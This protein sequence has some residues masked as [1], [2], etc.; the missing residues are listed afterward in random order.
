MA[1]KI[2]SKKEPEKPKGFLGELDVKIRNNRKRIS[3]LNKKFE[4]RVNEVHGEA[5]D[6]PRNSK[7]IRVLESE[8]EKL[9]KQEKKDRR[10]IMKLERKMKSAVDDLNAVK[11]LQFKDFEALKRKVN[12]QSDFIEKEALRLN[13]VLEAVQKGIMTKG[14]VSK[15]IV[16]SGKSTVSGI[17]GVVSNEEKALKLVS[18]YFQEIARTGFKKSLTLSEI[19]NAY[20]YVLGRLEGVSPSEKPVKETIVKEERVSREAENLMED[21]DKLKASIDASALKKLPERELKGFAYTNKK[22]VTY[23]LHNKGKL[24]YFSKDPMHAV[25]KPENMVVV[26]NKQT[27]LPLVKKKK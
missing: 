26:E 11:T 18:L 2:V 25:N 21:I 13:E 17:R 19:I 4:E 14:T 20:Q 16:S 3:A 24:Y 8:T 7:K 23:Y 12:E 9:K 22:G 10:R 27:G 1:E 6:S 5:R 15:T